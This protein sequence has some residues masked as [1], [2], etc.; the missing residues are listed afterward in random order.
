MR[1]V[2][3]GLAADQRID[4]AFLRLLVEVDA[5]GL[6]RIAFF[7]RLV[8]RLASP[9]PRPRCRAPGATPK[10]RPLGDAVA[11]VVD[12]V[13]ARHVL[14]LQEIGG[15][16]LALGEDRH[17]HVGAGDLLAA[18]GLHMDHGALDHALEA[19][20]GLAVIAAFG[21]QIVQL[22]LQIR[23]EIAL[24]LLQID[25]AGAHHR[26]GVLIVDQRQQQ[27]FERGVLVVALVGDR[28]GAV[29]GLL[30]AARECGHQKLI[31]TCIG[32][33]P[34]GFGSVTSSP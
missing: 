2:D 6:Q 22:G 29:K 26:G 30:E 7:L 9:A 5:V 34:Q 18:G 4:L 33:P 23:R 24:E 14:L 11:D 27:V 25:V 17:Q 8:A 19:C 16:A 3:L 31:S 15:V 32:R 1:A 13:V 28:Q 10:A 20:G 21:D 12:R